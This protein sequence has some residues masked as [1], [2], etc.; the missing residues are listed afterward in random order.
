MDL[1]GRSE[2]CWSDEKKNRLI[3]IVCLVSCNPW[4]RVDSRETLEDFWHESN[5][6]RSVQ[7]RN[8]SG[9]G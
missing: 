8:Y 4:V 3:G 1:R 5:V 2:R 9:S 7:Q 6:A